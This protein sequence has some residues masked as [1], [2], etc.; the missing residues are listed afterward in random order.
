MFATDRAAMS[1]IRSCLLRSYCFPF[2]F[3]SPSRRSSRYGTA[4]GS[5]RVIACRD[6]LATASGSVPFLV[7]P[8]TFTERLMPPTSQSQTQRIQLNETFRVALVVNSVSLK[9]CDAFVVKLIR[10]SP[11]D[12]HHVPAIHFQPRLA[13]HR[14]LHFIDHLAHQIE[15]GR[16]PEAVVN[17]VGELYPQ[18]IAQA[19]YLAIK[20]D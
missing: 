5:E 4:C 20:S 15:F 14:L 1:P 16:E 9:R 11:P 18:R 8:L 3:T 6:P 10:R 13:S 17:V 7:I 19:H 12:D 2:S